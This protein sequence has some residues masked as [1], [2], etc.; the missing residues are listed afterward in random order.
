MIRALMQL[1]D[2]CACFRELPK[3]RGLDT[4]KEATRTLLEFR[5]RGIVRLVV[6]EE[7]EHALECNLN[8]SASSAHLNRKIRTE[9][10]FANVYKL[11]IRALEAFDEANEQRTAQLMRGGVE[12]PS[13][14]GVQD[15]LHFRHPRGPRTAFP[16]HSQ[17][18]GVCITSS[19]QSLRRSVSRRHPHLSRE[20][21]Y[22]ILARSA[23]ARNSTS[24]G[25]TS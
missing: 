4:K 14:R 18:D 22:Q 10:C 5:V 21:D 3:R 11:T 20:H 23:G 15:G 1:R 8:A 9:L 6:C 17:S 24:P 12:E 16:S 25:F 7:R 2:R 19:T 13:A